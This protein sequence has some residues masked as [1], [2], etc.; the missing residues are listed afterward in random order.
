M[1]DMKD[2][3]IA[4]RI[5]GMQIVRDRHTKTL[6]LSQAEYVKIVLSMFAMSGSKSMSTPLAA[7]FRL[8]KMQELVFD[9]DIKHM[10]KILYYSVAGSI[11][12]AMV[13]SRP[14]LAYNIGLVSILM[15]NPGKEALECNKVGYKVSL[16]DCRV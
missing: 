2:M 1:F 7:H 15:G 14:N 9:Y 5:L 16:R 10:K 12:Y 8:S 6:F 4:T 13:W 3:G 11:M